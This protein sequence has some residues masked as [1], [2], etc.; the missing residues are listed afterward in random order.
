MNQKPKE[1]NQ[2]IDEEAREFTS[3]ITALKKSDGWSP[4]VVNMASEYLH[5]IYC[6]KTEG[7][8][9]KFVFDE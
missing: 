4:N 2:K 7:N 9:S 1:I 5:I 8:S 3:I 6:I